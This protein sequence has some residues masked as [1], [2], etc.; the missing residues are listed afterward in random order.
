MNSTEIVK[1]ATPDGDYDHIDTT[2]P[3]KLRI[4]QK[5]RILMFIYLT[6]GGFLCGVACYA[7]AELVGL[8]VGWASLSAILGTII[9]TSTLGLITLLAYRASLEWKLSN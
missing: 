1:I 3:N 8:S 6:L 9:A 7:A 2:T 5:L 4:G